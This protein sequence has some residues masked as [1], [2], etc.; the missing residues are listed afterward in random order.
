MT[1]ASPLQRLM[2]RAAALAAALTLAGCVVAPVEI[3]SGD[4]DG[5]RRWFERLDEQVDAYAVR[6]GG[7]AR[8]PGVRF[9][10]VDRLLA[11][12]A[13]EAAAS[14]AAWAA[15]GRR[16]VALDDAARNAEMANLPPAALRA[17]DVPDGAAAMGRVRA[18][19]P[20]LWDALSADAT[21]RERLRRAAVVPDDYSTTLRGLG[22]YPLTRWPFFSGVARELRQWQARWDA[23]AITNGLPAGWMRYRPG[24]AEATATLDNDRSTPWPRDALGM[25]ALDDTAAR[26]LLAA[27]APV[28]DIETT[29]D[30]DRPGRLGWGSSPAPEVDV[31]APVV[32]QRIAHTRWGGRTLPQLVYSVWF[33][34]RPARGPADL[35]AGR[36]DAVVLRITLDEAG[37]VLLLDSIHGC[38]CYH[39]FVP[40]PSLV[41]R[42]PPEPDI[43]WAFVPVRLPPLSPG[44]RL[45]VR[46]SAGDHQLVGVSVD[47]AAGSALT[48]ALLEEDGLRSLPTTSG[49]RRSAFWSSGIMPG[50]ERGERALFWPMGI[51]SPGAMRQWG[52]HPT[53]FVGRRHFDD[54]FLLEQ[55]FERRQVTAAP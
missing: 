50:T 49:A 9:L 53:A 17:L 54:P 42:A 47:D 40:T 46:I 41:P 19:A 25:V 30:H 4:S 7:A 31:R 16:L 34:E 29:A 35:L 13:G 1:I 15:W 21:A 36:V 43:E 22:L 18:C 33:T 14:E 27:H 20:R 32:Y 10:R 12:F 51:E 24:L 39:V 52:R 11:S 38:G 28:I 37:R 44:Q 26:R 8:V 45:R 5:C 2:L 55:R 48:Y 23:A 3:R 6:D